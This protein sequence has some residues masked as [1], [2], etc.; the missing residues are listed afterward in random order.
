V[1]S[2]PIPAHDFVKVEGLGNDFILVDARESS[3]LGRRA[4]AAD[5]WIESF[6][7][8]AK[9]LCDRRFGIGA[10]GVLLVLDPIHRSHAARMVVVNADGSRPEM[11][12]NGLRCVAA[13]LHPEDAKHG[14]IE[15]DTDAGTK[16]CEVRRL[17]H[18]QCIVRVEMGLAQVK[19][20]VVLASG[21]GMRFD[22]VDVGNPHSITFVDEDPEG[23]A[24]AIGPTIE[25]DERYPARTNVE[26]ARI[27][28]P[29]HVT[30]WVWER[31]CGITHA[32]GTGACA[33]IAA[34]SRR[35]LVPSEQDVRVDLPGGTLRVR[36][37]PVEGDPSSWQ[38]TMTGPARHVFAGR[39]EP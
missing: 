34:A 17:D 26:F 14:A 2:T 12:G 29:D 38:M 21:G 20:E 8:H 23:L 9:A 1:I 22:E 32:C 18:H 25:I 16:R 5:T 3:P 28:G 10:D 15:I 19:G 4:N 11:C 37:T 35:G 7:D 30:L 27:E 31:G 39:Y 36:A 24:R 13:F 33:T 6:R